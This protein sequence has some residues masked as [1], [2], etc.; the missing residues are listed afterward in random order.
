[1]SPTLLV[2]SC[3]FI[4]PFAS[5]ELLGD[6]EHGIVSPLGGRKAVCRG[7]EPAAGQAGYEVCFTTI[8]EL[9]AMLREALADQRA[10]ER[11]AEFTTLDVV[12]LDLCRVP[13]YVERSRR[14]RFVVQGWRISQPAHST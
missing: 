8:Q 14:S 5:G 12:I 9:A 3:R 13:G 2:V 7:A 11:I 4:S 10:E 1:V 6:S